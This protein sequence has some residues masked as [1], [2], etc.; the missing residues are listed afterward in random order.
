MSKIIFNEMQM[1]QLEKNENVVKVSERSITYCSDFKIK[2]VK[3]NQSGKGPNQIFL[4][5]GFDLEII[6]ERKPNQC[7]KRW[8]KTYEQFAEEGFYTERRGKGSAGRPSTKMLSS[9]DKLKK[10]EARIAFLEAELGILKKVRRTRKAGVTEETLTPCEKYTLIEQTI[11]RFNFPR[12]VR[13][14]CD[15]AGVSRSGYYAW[16]RKLDIH[17]EKEASDEK[18]YELIQEIFNRKKKKCGARF[19]KM[20]LENTKGITMNLKCIFRVMRKYNLVTKIRRANPYKQ[21]AKA[22]QEH[23]T[24]PNLLQRQFN[25]EEPEKSMLT[26][27]T[28]LFYGK[29]KKAYLSCVKDSTTREI[30]AYHVSPS[31]QMDIVYQTLDKLK[32][33][34]GDTIHPE[35]LLHSDQGIHYTHPEFQRRVKEMGLRQSMSRR[36]NCLDNAPMESFFGHMKDELDYKCCQTFQSLQLVIE[37][38]MQDY[39][40]D[41]Y[42]WT[43]KKMVPV[44]YRNH[45]L[46]A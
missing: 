10:A 13:Y 16:L 2:A 15:L 45:L 29:G 11:R 14:F 39:N 3:E 40:Y 21:I 26:D 38:Y 34:L 25:Q 20:A 43:L 5:N 32:D 28:Y 35:A 1:K 19:I 22:T 44:Q 8:R 23:K 4:E 37:K 18:D 17:I 33:R 12:M 41:R 30:L 24:C 42:Q 7:L 27:I 6:G 31:L 46:S 9:D 36:G